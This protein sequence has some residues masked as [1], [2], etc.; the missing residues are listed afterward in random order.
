MARD[1]SRQ[2]ASER[3][4]LCAACSFCRVV[5]PRSASHS[6]AQ[7]RYPIWLQRWVAENGG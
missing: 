1:A 6:A 2:S 5:L 3:S 4:R 7:P